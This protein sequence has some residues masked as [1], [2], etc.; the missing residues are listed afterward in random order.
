MLSSFLDGHALL[1]LL[2]FLILSPLATPARPP[3]RS[4]NPRVF[5]KT[6][7]TY[8][9]RQRGGCV[10]TAPNGVPMMQHVLASLGGA[11]TI[12]D[13]VN[14]NISNYPTQVSTRGLLFLFFGIIFQENHQLDP[15]ED[16]LNAYKNIAGMD[17]EETMSNSRRSVANQSFR[18][19][20]TDLELFLKP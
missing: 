18:C 13:S 10:R 7:N 6:F 4:L 1:Q 19:M 2:L 5:T 16:N 20:A 15:D 11:L 12:L 3:I 14:R 9:P 17:R 8:Q